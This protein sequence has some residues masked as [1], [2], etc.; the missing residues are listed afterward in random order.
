V[1]Y[2]SKQNSETVLKEIKQDTHSHVA[3]TVFGFFIAFSIWININL[4]YGKNTKIK[5][6]INL[7]AVLLLGRVYQESKNFIF[8]VID[9]Q[10]QNEKNFS[11]KKSFNLGSRKM[12]HQP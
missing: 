5:N 7:C 8:L 9:Q 11:K 3:G 4:R 2:L 12:T 6:K 10:F 1:L